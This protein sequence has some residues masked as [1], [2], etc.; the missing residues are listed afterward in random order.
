MRCSTLWDTASEVMREDGTASSYLMTPAVVSHNAWQEMRILAATARLLT[1][2][3]IVCTHCV[4][5]TAKLFY[6]V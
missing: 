5:L 6:T 3:Y 4:G 1:M 2:N